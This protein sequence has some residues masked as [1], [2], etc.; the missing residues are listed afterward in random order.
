MVDLQACSPDKLY[1]VGSIPHRAHSDEKRLH[2]ILSP[3]HLHGEWFD[4][5]ATYIVLLAPT[6]QDW[7]VDTLT[8][9]D[10]DPIGYTCDL[11]ALVKQV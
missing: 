11:W 9:Y 10:K 8:K 1:L 4:Q 7:V 5:R 6:F 3:F 2:R